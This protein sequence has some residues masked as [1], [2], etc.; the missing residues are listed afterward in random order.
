MCRVSIVVEYRNYLYVC[1][2]I[3]RK[4]KMQFKPPV[5]LNYLPFQ[6]YTSDV[7]LYVVCFGVDFCTVFTFYVS[8]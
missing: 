8:R 3:I 6:G 1:I 4:S 2:Y 7:V 5:I